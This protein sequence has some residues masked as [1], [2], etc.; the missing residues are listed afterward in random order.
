MA[1]SKKELAKQAAIEAEIKEKLA[2]RLTRDLEEHD[3]KIQKSD[4]MFKNTRVTSC[5]K[6]LLKNG[7]AIAM[8]FNIGA[9][10]P[11][12]ATASKLPE[13][14]SLSAE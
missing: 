12:D 3:V 13:G 1:I 11:V 5:N 8:G 14:T 10:K 4:M 9:P 6:V 7:K 2:A